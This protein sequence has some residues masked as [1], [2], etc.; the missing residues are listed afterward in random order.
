MESSNGRA[1][2]EAPSSSSSDFYATDSPKKHPICTNAV[3]GTATDRIAEPT[4]T[5]GPDEDDDQDD[6][7]SVEMDLSDSRSPTPGPPPRANNHPESRAEP[8]AVA[9]SMPHPSKRKLSEEHSSTN[10]TAQIATESS[11]KPKLSATP[12]GEPDKTVSKALD[13]PVELWQQIFL[14]LSPNNLARCVRVCRNFKVY[15]TETKSKP[16]ANKAEAKDLT[17]VRV[18]D[19]EAVWAHSRKTFHPNM[20][21]PLARLT[22]LQMLQL[23][24][25]L[26]CQ[27]CGRDPILLQPSTPFN[28]G[29]GVEGVRVFWPFGI[30]SCG[31]CVDNNT[32]KVRL[33]CS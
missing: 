30:R 14:H 22:E 28:C 21:R 26:K 17:K 7:S 9:V 3:G 11:K 19:S 23:I 27:F 25:N 8:I 2:S 33:Y 4:T 15:L 16:V 5:S 24:G 32:L 18:L 31:K 1:G 12:S 13:L 10:G 6:D 20:P 29:P